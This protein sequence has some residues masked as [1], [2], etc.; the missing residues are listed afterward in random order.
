MILCFK[1]TLGS[2][3][4]VFISLGWEEFVYVK[5]KKPQKGKIGDDKI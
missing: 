5:E 2:H 3:W 4:L 1:S